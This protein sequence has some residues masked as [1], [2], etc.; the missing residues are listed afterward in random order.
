MWRLIS[1]RYTKEILL[2]REQLP[3]GEVILPQRIQSTVYRIIS[4]PKELVK[5]SA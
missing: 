3:S 1:I 2:A 4:L 5:N